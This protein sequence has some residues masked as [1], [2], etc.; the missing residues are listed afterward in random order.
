MHHTG[1]LATPAWE[2][3]L[4]EHHIH[5]ILT[6]TVWIH[7]SPVNTSHPAVLTLLSTKQTI[8]PWCLKNLF[9]K[10]PLLFF[11]SCYTFD[12]NCDFIK[13]EVTF[14]ALIFLTQEAAYEKGR[15]FTLMLQLNRFNSKDKY[16]NRHIHTLQR[17]LLPLQSGWGFRSLS[18]THWFVPFLAGGVAVPPRAWTS[19]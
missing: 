5:K 15:I 18:L 17:R 9:W 12:L 2:C 1:V 13:K 4:Q 14:S 6:G 8:G 3:D 11:Y 16:L 10:Q 7:Q 19:S